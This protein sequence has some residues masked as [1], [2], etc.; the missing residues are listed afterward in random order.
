M[1]TTV[2][3]SLPT[4]FL[5]MI[6][7]CI[8]A[9]LRCAD[10]KKT[11]LIRSAI[12]ASAVIIYTVV[13]ILCLQPIKANGDEI[14]YITQTGSKYHSSECRHLRQSRIQ[15]TLEQAI[16]G[17]YDDCAHCSVAQYIPQTITKSFPDLYSKQGLLIT[18][19]CCAIEFAYFGLLYALGTW[20]DRR[21]EKRRKQH[22]KKNNS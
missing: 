4:L 21:Q 1:D 3:L 6:T 9:Q 2:D 5:L 7:V 12:I 16:D 11:I 20:R 13:V 17:G 14:V 8:V 10:K 18:V 19:L 22:S 15:T